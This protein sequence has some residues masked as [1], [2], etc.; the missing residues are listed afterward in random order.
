MDYFYNFIK[1][2]NA[3]IPKIN[4]DDVK[5]SINNSNYLL[6]NTLPNH[7]QNCLIYKTIHFASEE[8]II[9]DLVNNNK[10]H[11]IIIYGKN[12]NDDSVYKKYNQFIDL[13]FTNVYLYLGG[14]FEWLLL[15]DIYGKDM[16]KTTS[17]ELDIIK[18][19]SNS[20]LDKKLILN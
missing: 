18:Y 16:F 6:I 11:N 14:L 1:G 3:S 19:K 15:Q 7:E 2:T 12:C 20:I 8:Q 13:G 9:N 5:L 4:Y 10:S 17:N